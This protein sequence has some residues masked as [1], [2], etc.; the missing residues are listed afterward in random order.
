MCHTCQLPAGKEKSSRSSH[1]S[2]FEGHQSKKKDDYSSP[3]RGRPK[4]SKSKRKRRHSSST[5]NSSSDD[6][7]FSDSE[8]SDDSKFYARIMML[9]SRT[10][11]DSVVMI[12]T[13]WCHNFI[14]TPTVWCY[15]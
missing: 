6:L 7:D 4:T 9:Y 5:S 2:T 15:I 14:R 1:T 8:S 10:P 12:P 13:V 3:E 11:T